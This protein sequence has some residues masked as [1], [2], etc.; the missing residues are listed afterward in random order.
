MEEVFTAE[1][2]LAEVQEYAPLLA[3]KKRLSAGLVALGR[4]YASRNGSRL[5]S[6]R[7]VCLGSPAADWPPRP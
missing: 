4:G 5:V 7:K 2:T 6:L 3:R 1:T